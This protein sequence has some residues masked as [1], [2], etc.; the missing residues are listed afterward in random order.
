MIFHF[1]ANKYLRFTDLPWGERLT[2]NEHAARF[3]HGFV[4]NILFSPFEKPFSSCFLVQRKTLRWIAD[5]IRSVFHF[6]FTVIKTFA[7][8]TIFARE[9]SVYM[10]NLIRLLLPPL[11]TWR[12][13]WC[14]SA[15]CCV[16]GSKYLQAFWR[17][18]ITIPS[19]DYS[20]CAQLSM[21]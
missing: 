3:K 20:N 18:Y 10:I 8:Q 4:F 7:V 21:T 6:L 1:F 17:S 2:P 14:C 13:I 5:V 15:A 9:Y 16:S 19:N 11:F 12:L